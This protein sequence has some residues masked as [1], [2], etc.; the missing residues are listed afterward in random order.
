MFIDFGLAR[1]IVSDANGNFISNKFKQ[2]CSQLNKTDHNLITSL[3]EQWTGRS[4]HKIHEE[5]HQKVP[6]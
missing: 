2:F 3:L 6:L 5:H 1:K 4:M